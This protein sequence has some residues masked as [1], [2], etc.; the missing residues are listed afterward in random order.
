[1]NEHHHHPGSDD[2]LESL[3]QH[4]SRF[5]NHRLSKKRGQES[6]LSKIAQ[7]PEITQ[8]ELAQ[9][10]GIQPASVSELLMKLES[11]GMVL[12]EKDE[13]DRR[14][15]RIVLTPEGQAFLDRPR[16][17]AADPF[18]ALSPEEQ[19]QLKVLLTKLLHDWE[20]R[21]PSEHHHGHPHHCSRE[22]PGTGKGAG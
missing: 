22:E 3:L 4:C 2:S 15:F 16:E 13:Q 7:Q 9:Q 20:Q 12:R 1:M 14:N 5:F 10:L 17:E 21:F 18:R 19:A 8:K 11:K 6:V